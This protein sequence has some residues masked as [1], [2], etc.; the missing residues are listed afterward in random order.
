MTTDNSKTRNRT[1]PDT[2]GLVGINV[3]IPEALHKRVRVK[4]VNN[5][6]TMTDAIE[7]ALKAWL[8]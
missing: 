3:L 8:R 5:G 6:L 7:Q 2:T 1:K 4:S